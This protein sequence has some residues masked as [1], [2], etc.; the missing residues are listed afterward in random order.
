MMR[1]IVEINDIGNDMV[2]VAV[3]YDK[4]NETEVELNAT[5]GLVRAIS[6]LIDDSNKMSVKDSVKKILDDIGKN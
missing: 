4:E 1:L 2:Q 3:C 5:G 6:N